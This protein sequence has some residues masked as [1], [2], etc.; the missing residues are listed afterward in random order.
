MTTEKT[1]EMLKKLKGETTDPNLQKEF[2][3]KIK[4]LSDKKTVEK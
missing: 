1:I 3:E 4:T 2:D